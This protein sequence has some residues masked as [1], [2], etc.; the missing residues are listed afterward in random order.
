MQR[1]FIA[2]GSNIGDRFAW[3]QQ[4]VD[5]LCEISDRLRCSPVYEN[6]AHTLHADDQFPDFLNAVVEAQI[7]IGEEELLDHCQKIERCAKR[8]RL[9]PY[10]PRTLDLDLLVVGDIVCNTCHITLPHPRLQQRRFVLQPWYD[11]APDYMIP[12]PVNS[13]VKDALGRCQDLSILAK[14]SRSLKSS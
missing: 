8:Q 11:L 13:T 4:A 12:S 9:H 14:I 7:S 1:A 10:G 3:L 6:A 5:G 2:L